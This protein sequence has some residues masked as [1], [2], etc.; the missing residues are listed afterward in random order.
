MKTKLIFTL[1]VLFL[2]A[3]FGMQELKAQKKVQTKYYV[4]SGW[5]ENG[6]T[7]ERR[8]FVANVVSVSC[9]NQSVFMV[10]NQFF[11]FYKAFVAKK[12]KGFNVTNQNYTYDTDT[13]EKAEKK[14]REMIAKYNEDWD[15]CLINDFSVLC[16]DDD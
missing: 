15:T 9:E 12:H 16:E 7:E 1:S 6:A 14:R 3:L 4:V 5:L 10:K 2:S 11:D 13:R 8:P